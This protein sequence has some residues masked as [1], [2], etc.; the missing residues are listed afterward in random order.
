VFVVI[1]ATPRE[2]G[3]DCY[4]YNRGSG[5]TRGVRDLGQQE[6]RIGVSPRV[7]VDVLSRQQTPLVFVSLDC[8]VDS[9]RPRPMLSRGV[10]GQLILSARFTR[11]DVLAARRV[12]REGD[13]RF[14]TEYFDYRAAG[15]VDGAGQID[16][17]FVDP[18]APG[19]AEVIGKLALGVVGPCE[20]QVQTSAA[21]KSSPSWDHDVTRRRIE[22]HLLTGS[23]FRGGTSAPEE[24]RELSEEFPRPSPLPETTAAIPVS[25]V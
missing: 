2:S 9:V 23:A 7:S 18:E 11:R 10:E 16:E 21:R 22:I 8:R 12:I 1:P 6:N 3:S 20:R 25:R 17:P 15:R 14:V 13:L 19:A 24:P 4:P 5:L